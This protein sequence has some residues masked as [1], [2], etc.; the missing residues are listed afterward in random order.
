MAGLDPDIVAYYERGRERARL[1]ENPTGRLELIRTRFVLRQLLPA[2][3]ARVLDVG[4]AAG[5]HAQWLA[6]EGYYVELIDP[7]PL[8]V[9]QARA[10][11]D[12]QPDAPFSVEI[13][14][15]RDLPLDDG[16][17]DAVL[18]MG[19]LYHLPEPADRATVL[20]E[21]RRVLRTEGVLAAAAISRFA[22]TL[23]GV[24]R[25]FI[26]DERFRDIAGGDLEHGVHR[27]PSRTP[28]YF[29]TSYFHHPEDLR[30]EL[31][32]AGFAEV[33]VRAV[34][35]FGG[36]LGDLEARLDD[37]SRAPALLDALASVDQEASMLGI[38][39]HLLGLGRRPSD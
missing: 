37:A 39:F 7:M 38:S 22:S 16:S 12:A 15:A 1:H 27:N 21:A 10:C 34:E 18:L 9:E 19:P 36:M 35:G 13:G 6:R 11:S 28:G 14:D 33:E 29:T 26:L 24:L 2:P 8:H 20:G 5:V 23:D 17:V 3:P 31:A 25:D 4:G 32:A 30:S